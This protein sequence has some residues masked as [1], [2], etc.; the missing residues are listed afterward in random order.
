MLEFLETYSKIFV[1]V[2]ENTNEYCLPHFLSN[3]PTEIEIEIIEIE[4]GE[5]TMEV[6]FPFVI[7]CQ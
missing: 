4:A 2:D 1:L 7:A 5:E 3:L 6:A